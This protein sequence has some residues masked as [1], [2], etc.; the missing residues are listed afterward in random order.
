MRNIRIIIISFDNSRIPILV[1]VVRFT[2]MEKKSCDKT[3]S[4]VWWKDLHDSF[5][6]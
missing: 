3:K 2:K 6:F 4:L 5:N 1:F